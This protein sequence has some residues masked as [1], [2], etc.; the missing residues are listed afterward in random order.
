MTITVD[1]SIALKW[2]PEEPRSAAAEELLEKDL[3]VPS[4]WLL[5]QATLAP[6][7]P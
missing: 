6:H 4:L 3:G 5:R 2:V 7:G 1:A